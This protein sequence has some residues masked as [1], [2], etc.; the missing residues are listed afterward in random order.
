MARRPDPDRSDPRV[1][2][3]RRYKRDRKRAER[4]KRVQSVLHGPKGAEPVLGRRRNAGLILVVV[5][6]ILA[7]MG[8]LSGHHF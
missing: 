2:D 6:A 7:A 3:L 4:A 1:T 8:L 5:I